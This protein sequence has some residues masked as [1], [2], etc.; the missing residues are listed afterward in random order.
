VCG[1]QSTSTWSEAIL[2]DGQLVG[3]AGAG[4][5]DWLIEIEVVAVVPD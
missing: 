5:A 2:I 1:E 4:G 3:G